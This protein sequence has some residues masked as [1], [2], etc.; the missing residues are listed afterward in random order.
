MKIYKNKLYFNSLILSAPGII[1]IFLSL[2]AIP[3]HLNYLGIENY[4]SYIFFHLILSF[5]F[6][7]NLGIPKSIVIASGIFPKSKNKIAFDGIKYSFF[8]VSLILILHF[9]N[10]IYNFFNYDNFSINYIVI[11]VIFSIIYLFLEGIL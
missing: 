10:S 5:S 7:L 1:S 4:G 11:G 6:L 2:F 3:V 8:I 9:I